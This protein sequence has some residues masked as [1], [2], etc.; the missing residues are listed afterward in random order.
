M[1]STNRDVTNIV[2]EDADD[3]DT[4]EARGN[5]NQHEKRN[6]DL[7]PSYIIGN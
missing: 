2:D 6:Q 1:E 7:V 3:K 4:W 5:G